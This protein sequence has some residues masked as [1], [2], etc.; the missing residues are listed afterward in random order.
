[1]VMRQSNGLTWAVLFNTSTYR[2]TTLARDVRR[3]VQPAL[4]SVES[5]PEHDL[6]YYSESPAIPLL[7]PAAPLRPSE[8]R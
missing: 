5:W 1:L 2:G 8:I 6:F 3:I 7:P 4:N